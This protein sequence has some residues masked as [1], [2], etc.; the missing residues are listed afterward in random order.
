[1]TETSQPAVTE[2][3]IANQEA[4]QGER[5]TKTILWV[6]A[7]LLLIGGVAS[8]FLVDDSSSTPQLTP[9]EQPQ[10]GLKLN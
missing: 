7:A 5:R 8:F 9:A 3:L 2:G 4:R 10:P 6:V 1:M